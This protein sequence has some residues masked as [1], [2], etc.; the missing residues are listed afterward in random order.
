MP[1]ISI[2][3]T[4]VMDDDTEYTVVVDQR[5]VAAFELEHRISFTRVHSECLAAFMRWT[6]WHALRRTAKIDVTMKFKDFDSKLA[7]ATD[8]PNE[9]EEE[10]EPEVDPT[11]P[12][13]SGES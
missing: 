11:K 5:D 12:D 2:P 1:G 9:G 10:T 4:A 13:P 6:A 7:Y 3:L 8:E